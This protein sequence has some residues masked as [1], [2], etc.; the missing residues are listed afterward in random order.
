M[1][2]SMTLERRKML[3]ALG[4]KIVLTPA[5]LGM[6]GALSK[7][8]E[9][10]NKLDQAF[11]PNQFDNQANP[12]VHYETTGPEIF[13]DTQGSVDIVVAGV[14]TGGTIAGMSRYFREQEATTQIVAVEPTDSAVLSG[15]PPGPHMIQGIGAG[16]IPANITTEDYDQLI[17][18]SNEEAFKTT[19]QLAQKEG[20]LCGMSSG[21]NVF[22]AVKCAQASY[23]K[24]KTIVCILCDF[25]E[26]YLSTTL[27]EQEEINEYQVKR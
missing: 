15:N 11:I 21:A 16:F 19:R 4:A 1:P 12:Q 5:H 25:G 13:K 8:A 24:G 23:N 22:A 9:L 3:M 17:Q 6:S 10:A 18:V 14:G 7:A 27:F 2:E 26:R 20:V